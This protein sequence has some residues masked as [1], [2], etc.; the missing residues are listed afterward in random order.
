MSILVGKGSRILIQ[1]ITGR[2][3]S[4]ILPDM[5]KYGS[6]VLAGVTPGKGG[7]TI[8][9]IPV[10]DSVKEALDIHSEINTSLVYVPPFAAK[11]A[12]M[13][14]LDNGIHLLN[15]VTERVPVRDSWAIIKKAKELNARVIGPTSL[16]IISP[17]KCKLG[18]IGGNDPSSVYQEGSIG[19]MSK[20]GGMTTETSWVLR[21]NDFG[22]STAVGLGG[23]V[24]M[25]SMFTDLLPLFNEDQQT[26][27]IVI[28]GELGGL[29]ENAVAEYVKHF[30]QPKPIVAFIAGKFSEH[31]PQAIFGHAGAIIQ[32]GKD[33]PHEKIKELET[34]GIR[35]AKVHHEIGEILKE[36]L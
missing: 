1:G 20:S 36:V 31:L 26:K 11:Q 3:A 17:G 35:V 22:Q 32:G 7:Q 15:V 10:Y 9:G 8:Q 30:G 14:A 4:M 2:E 24:L 6:K 13:E 27:A 16:G 5:L 33:S 25:G 34:A 21:L 23:D 28:F 29:Q 12:C 19:V 18:P